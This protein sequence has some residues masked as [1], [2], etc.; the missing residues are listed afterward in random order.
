MM[1]RRIMYGKP[2]WF[3]LHAAAV[4]LVFLLGYT[5]RF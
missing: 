1:L 4:F 2:G 3:I 5:A